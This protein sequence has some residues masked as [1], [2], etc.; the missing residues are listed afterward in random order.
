MIIG[1]DG[2][3]ANIEK[4][5][6][7]NMYAYEVL[8]GI[9]RLQDNLSNNYKFIVYLKNKP[10]DDLPKENDYWRYE[11]LPGRGLWIITRLM[12]YLMFLKSKPDLLFSPSHYTVP[13]SPIPRICSIMDLGYLDS[14]EQFKKFTY[15]QLRLWTAISVYV[16]KYVIAISNATKQ[17]IVRHY[18]FASNKIKVTHLAYDRKRFNN[19]IPDSDVRRVRKKYSIV[20]DYVL[21]LSTLKPSK[22]IE[23]LMEAYASIINNQSSIIKGRTIK[24]VIAGKKGWMYES[25]FAKVKQLRLEKEVIFT[26]Y[27]SEGDK[28]ALF[29][30]AKIFVSPSFWEGFGLHALESMACGVPVVVSNVGSY[31][32]IVGEAGILVNPYSIASIAEGMLRV[33]KM[34]ENEYNKVVEQSLVQAQKFSWEKTARSTFEIL[35]SINKEK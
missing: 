27:V 6:G 29:R 13:I 32:E 12:P 10:L 18:A 5:V 8:W 9:Y 20:D 28:P 15:W 19:D 11:V 22:N 31:P 14:S 26:D 33:L 24:L 16:S 35:K 7:V 3:E 1:I 34:N 17:D 30:G 25:I 23:G 21:F 4:R 2:N